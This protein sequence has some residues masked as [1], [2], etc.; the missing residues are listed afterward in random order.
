LIYVCC[1]CIVDDF[2]FFS[3][4]QGTIITEWDRGTKENVNLLDLFKNDPEWLISQLVRIAEYY[5]FD[6]WFINIEAQ[7]PSK[8]H[9]QRFL[10]FMNA[11]RTKLHSQ[12]PDSLLIWY[13]LFLMV[14]SSS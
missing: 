3:F 10:E 6:G 7:L 14:F 13:I 12:L 5:G 9:V 2:D 8:D 11:L 4:S 1:C